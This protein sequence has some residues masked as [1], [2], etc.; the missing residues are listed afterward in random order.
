ME[1]SHSASFGDLLVGFLSF[2]LAFPLF[3]IA[4]KQLPELDWGYNL[5]RILLFVVIILLLLLILRLFRFIIVIGVLAAIAWLTYGSTTGQYGFYD[6]YGDYRAMIYT[7]KDDPNPMGIIFNRGS[8]FPHQSEFLTAMDDNNPVVRDFA[9]SAINENFKAEQ[10][11][12]YEYRTI[13]QCFAIFKKINSN[14]NYVNDSRSREYFAKASES[15]KQMAG[16]CDDHS[17]LMVAA[18]QSVGGEPRLIH[19]TGHVYPEILIGNKN[20]LEQVN[21]LIKKRLFTA[22]SGDQKINYHED[23]QGRIWLN[24][25]YT[26]KYPGG[27]FMAE[28]VLG[29]LNL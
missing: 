7:M 19:T 12:Y 3:I 21:Y 1:R 18:I 29:V 15:V 25:D 22:E 11:K 26:A 8:S 16:D 5:D 27:P 6:L 28:K 23:K 10:Q 14:W 4:H 2:F 20:D 9:L 17:I 24:L 13:I